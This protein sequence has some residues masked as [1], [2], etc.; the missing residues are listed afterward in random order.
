[1]WYDGD[2]S[3]DAGFLQRPTHI[4]EHLHVQR[5]PFALHI[6]FVWTSGIDNKDMYADKSMDLE[7]F[8][9]LFDS[10]REQRLV[11]LHS[12]RLVLIQR[13]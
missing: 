7:P 4:P 2:N 11:V 6:G 5:Q 10:W 12:Y 1:M 13:N 8:I 9:R 3:D